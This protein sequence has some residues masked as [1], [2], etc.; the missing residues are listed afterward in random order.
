MCERRALPDGMSSFHCDEKLYA[1]K[2][3]LPVWP[4]D[5]Q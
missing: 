1:V 3:Q 2:L 4:G 5:F